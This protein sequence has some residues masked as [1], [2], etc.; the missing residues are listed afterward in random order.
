MLLVPVAL[1]MEFM[2][3]AFVRSAAADVM[4]DNA[5]AERVDRAL[6]ALALPGDA[7]TSL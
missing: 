1:Q 3:A 6:A 5:I 7:S 4:S 2:P